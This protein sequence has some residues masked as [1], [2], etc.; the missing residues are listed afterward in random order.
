MSAE[1][2]HEYRMNTAVARAV[3]RGKRMVRHALSPTARV[4]L[5]RAER[6]RWLVGV[7]PRRAKRQRWLVAVILRRAER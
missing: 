7:I 5:R 1:R 2:L 3:A 6:Q 4:I